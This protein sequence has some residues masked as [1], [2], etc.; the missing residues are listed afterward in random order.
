MGVR[1]K[2][3]VMRVPD[4]LIHERGSA[5]HPSYF[6]SVPLTAENLRHVLGRQ[7]DYHEDWYFEKPEEIQFESIEDIPEPSPET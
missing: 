7:Q 4:F 5:R 2:R 6:I 3:V 1:V